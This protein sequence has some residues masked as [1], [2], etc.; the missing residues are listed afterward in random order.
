MNSIFKVSDINNL[1]PENLVLVDDEH[2]GVSLGIKSEKAFDNI[3]FKFKKI[4]SKDME[5]GVFLIKSN[6]DFYSCYI[7]MN[8]DSNLSGLKKI[9]N[10]NC[11]NLI[12]FNKSN[13][14]KVYRINNDL[15]NSL[16]L[17]YKPDNSNNHTDES[18][19]INNLISELRKKYTPESLW[20]N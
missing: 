17:E 15:K 20:N 3:D 16:L 14:N 7:D 13:Y 9:I 19:N 12:V 1:T 6:N 18:D 4:Q 8:E 11:F 5:C 10:S 2:G